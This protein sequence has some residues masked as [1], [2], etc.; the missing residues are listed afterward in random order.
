MIPKVPGQGEIGSIKQFNNAKQL[1]NPFDVSVEKCVIADLSERKTRPIEDVDRLAERIINNGFERTRAIRC[2][3]MGEKYHVF[4]GGTRLQACRKL[5]LPT[6]PA[7]IYDVMSDEEM[8]RLSHEDNAN[9]DYHKP[10]PI[11]DI[12]A[13]YNHLSID[14]GWTQDKIAKVYD[15]TRAMVSFRINLHELP[16]EIKKYV[17]QGLLTETQTIELLRLSI[18]LHFS[19]WLTTDE[20]RLRC[21]RELIKNSLPGI[22]KTVR[23]SKEYI[24]K[25]KDI[26]EE[27]ET[28]RNKLIGTT[29]YDMSKD[30][31]E[32]FQYDAPKEFVKR[33]VIKEAYTLSA[34]RAAALE[35]SELIS[36]NLKLYAD[37]QQTK[38]TA[39]AIEA[40]R[41]RK[42]QEIMDRV[43]L[44][45]SREVIRNWNHGPVKLILTDPPY[46]KF[47]RGTKRRSIVPDV[48]TGDDEN[49]VSL[50]KEVIKG[51]FPHLAEN[52]HVIVFTDWQ[53]EPVVRGALQ[54]IGL[55]IRGQLIWVKENHSIGD[56]NHTFAPKHEVMV[57]AVK[58]RPIVSPRLPDVFDIPRTHESEHPT[59]KPLKLLKQL[60][61]SCSV[62]NDTILDPFGGS[63][64]TLIAGLDLHRNAYMIEIDE[65]YVNMAFSRLE[66]LLRRTDAGVI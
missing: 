21:A 60:I 16:N 1:F 57:H 35:I 31:P 14:L 33:L 51:F 66:A 56:V 23:A 24:E 64:S 3:L 11:T 9:D 15:V 49:A 62:E 27:S 22:P 20:I 55:A 7:F 5:N 40:E 18:N 52:A 13:E 47:Y 41:L 44:G 28:I 42:K 54:D 46:G 25:W 38:S 50:T 63:G 8:A 53:H 34:V 30:L 10:V 59:E 29:L 12:W 17:N 61:D 19:E 39:A 43:I 4:A 65:Q 48:L 26:I 58:G 32:P 6:I 45:D 2:V 36:K 37:Y